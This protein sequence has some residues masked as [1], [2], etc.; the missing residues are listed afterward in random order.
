MWIFADNTKIHALTDQADFLQDDINNFMTWAEIQEIKFNA[1]RCKVIHS[2][3]NNPEHNYTME[4]E[5][6]SAVDE[7]L[8]LVL[9]NLDIPFPC[10]QCRSRS[11][12]FWRS[13]SALFAIKCANL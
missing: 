6:L 12:G 11:V 7:A 13:G 9:L 2:E 8:T 1:D 4:N 5:N 3:Q 10:K